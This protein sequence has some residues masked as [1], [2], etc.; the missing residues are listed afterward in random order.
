MCEIWQGK[1][2]LMGTY[3]CPLLQEMNTNAQESPINKFWYSRGL[4]SEAFQPSS[5]SSFTLF[6]NDF[7]HFSVVILNQMM[8]RLIFHS[9]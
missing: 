8:T 2:T 1:V 7:L 4:T 5:I 3:T 9:S 6:V